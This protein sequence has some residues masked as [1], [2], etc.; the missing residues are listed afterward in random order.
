[1]LIPV[2]IPTLNGYD[3]DATYLQNWVTPLPHLPSLAISRWQPTK[4]ITGTGFDHRSS[5]ATVSIGTGGNG[6]LVADKITVNTVDPPY[7]I[8]GQKYA[9]YVPSMVGLK[10]EM[11]STIRL[12]AT[13]N[14]KLYKYVIDFDNLVEGSQLWLFSRVIDLD[15]AMENL[16][17]LLSSDSDA[18][19]F[20]KKDLA[21]RQLIFFGTAPA[22]FLSVNCFTI[23]HEE[24]PHTALDKMCMV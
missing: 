19:V 24:H 12:A 23:D 16:T 4:S 17:V 10:E 13:N 14:P 3:M 15:P 7:W 6:T 11:T 21:N 20:Y 1:M 2:D 8:N 9:T 18:K 22:G 5:G